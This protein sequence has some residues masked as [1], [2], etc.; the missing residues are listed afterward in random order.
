MDAVARNSTTKMTIKVN[1]LNI[2]FTLHFEMGKNRKNRN[3][4]ILTECV[5]NKTQT[6]VKIDAE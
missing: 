3:K 5:E 4:L 2:H 6:G 1:F